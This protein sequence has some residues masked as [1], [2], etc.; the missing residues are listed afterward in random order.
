MPDVS[1]NVMI[2]GKTVFAHGV[3]GSPDPHNAIASGLTAAGMHFATVL[4]LSNQA[5]NPNPPPSATV[6]AVGKGDQGP[7]P[8]T[9]GPSL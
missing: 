5:P 8:T 9:K 4:A 6:G 3:A 2:D 1:I 7:S